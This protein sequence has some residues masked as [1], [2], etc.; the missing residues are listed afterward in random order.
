M[1]VFSS[2]PLSAFSFS[3][4]YSFNFFF[5]AWSAFKAFRGREIKVHMSDLVQTNDTVFVNPGIHV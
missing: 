1:S 2:T 3:F 4:L 5:V